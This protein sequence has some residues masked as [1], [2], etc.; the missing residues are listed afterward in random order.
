M[1][2]YQNWLCAFAVILLR[3][4]AFSQT[5][6]YVL[7]G[8]ATRISC[9]CYSLTPAINSLS[10]SVW[11]ANKIDL[12]TSFDFIFNVYLGCK[13]ADGADGL[14]FMLQP[15][16]TSVGA[17]GQGIGF[18]GV[19][20]SVG[21]VLDTW[22]NIELNDPSYDHMSIQV[23]GNGKHGHD[24]AGPVPISTIKP[25]VEDCQWHTLRITWDAGAQVLRSYFDNELRL[26]THSDIIRTIFNNNPQVY[27]GFSAG[28][29]VGNNVQKFCTALNPLFSTSAGDN[30]VCLNTPV[31]FKNESQ[32]FA[33][34]MSCYWDFGD[35]QASSAFSPLPHLYAAPGLYTVKLS[36]TGFDGCV[37]DTL[38]K[39]IAIG[40]HP[41]A[42][43]VV[44]EA[45]SS[46]PPRVADRSTSAVGYV[47]KWNW[48]LDGSAVSSSQN[49]QF[50]NLSPG[51]HELSLSVV[52]NYGCP[53][54]TIH[55]YFE[56]KPSPVISSNDITGCI[57]EPFELKA[58][59]IDSITNI[60]SW[61]WK[62]G[63][64]QTGNG[65]KITGMY[66]STGEYMYIVSA[67]ADNGCESK[68]VAVFARIREAVADAGNDTVIIAAHPFRLH[69]S[70]GTAYDW[71]PALGL[72]N[73]TSPDPVALLQ[74]D[75]TYTLSITTPEGC[76]DEDVINI[77][78]FR[79]SGINVPTAFTPNND[80][81]NDVLR[82]AYKGIKT[83]DHFSVY[84]RWGKALFSTKN[85]T[86][87][88]N[89][90]YDGTK[91]P[92]G[93]YV[94]ILKATDYEG[95]VYELKGTSVLIR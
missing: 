7:N 28:T 21:V 11:N 86:H 50:N 94:W 69:A 15:I 32:S 60:I 53:S 4:T 27:W 52:S 87:G 59:Q 48:V 66:R 71:L 72:D 13:D 78:I 45:C 14:V 57:N 80:G 24:L 65:Q 92:S 67:T 81:L 35:G 39:T 82:P 10:G 55:Q 40:D 46:K 79:G 76:K 1:K 44:S 84:N 22:Q 26:H 38:K 41:K 31:S 9:N 83:L 70:G 49:P 34:I 88:W 17:G 85:I 95:K 89:G 8:S 3:L 77:K 12:K 2:S 16:N 42:G 33:P 5:N 75:M 23:N 58:N 68:P 51:I 91:Q 62:S 54:E 30:G 47:T 6:A 43:F 64:G 90:N 93:A 56:V 61:Q 37:S 19:N 36:I 29:G 74:D 18:L 20:P 25:N 63:T 73:P